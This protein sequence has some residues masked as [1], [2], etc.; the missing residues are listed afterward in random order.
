MSSSAR[1]LAILGLFDAE[2]PVWQTETI[3]AALGLTRATGSRGVKELVDA[4]LLRKVSAGH[5]SPGPRLIELDHQLRCSDPVLLAAAP[6]MDALAREAGAIDPGLHVPGSGR[7]A[8]PSERRKV[9]M[10][11]LPSGSWAAT[12]ITTH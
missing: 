12:S 8:A 9:P 11:G 4:G 2:H 7:C 10:R 3:H 6:V 5:C 1:V